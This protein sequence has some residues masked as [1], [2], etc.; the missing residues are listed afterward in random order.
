[1]KILFI[2]LTA[3]Y[4]T[5]LMYQG[6]CMNNVLK[7]QGHEITFIS[8]VQ[9]FE[10]G[11]LKFSEP[12]DYID[13]DGIRLIRVPYLISNA[14]GSKLKI[15]SN[16]YKY[17]DEISP[18]IIY[19]HSP[20]YFSVFEVI[21]YKKA[22]PHVKIFAD[23]HTGYYNVNTKSL[24]FNILYKFYYRILY[25]SL[26]PFL[27]KYFYIGIQDKQFSKEIFK[28]N[29]LKMEFFPLGS[30]E[31]KKEQYNKFR[32]EKRRELSYND[33]DIVILHSGKL[34]K[35][36]NT[37][38]LIDSFS[39]LDNK[40]KLLIIGSIPDNNEE[41]YG[42]IKNNTNINYLGWKNSQELVKYICACDVYAQPGSQSITLLSALCART[43]VISYSHDFYSIYKDIDSILWMKSEEDLTDNL[44]SLSKN[45]KL[46]ELKKNADRNAYKYDYANLIN[47]IHLLE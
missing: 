20:Q 4:T 43:P 24:Y 27:E 19:C 25:K 42:L 36:K 3:H 28:A 40:Y 37:K 5:G 6:N 14:I 10:N 23:T 2:G 11:I 15:F 39:K 22:N 30:Y 7:S 18:D 34:D 13:S 35:Q 1:M 8:D 47:N 9:Y 29:E 46:A 16:I 33:Y 32:T 17:M 12:S 44:K 45:G 31:V 21:K 26:E 41:L 38:M